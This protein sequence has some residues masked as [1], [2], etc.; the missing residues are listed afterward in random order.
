M[1]IAGQSLEHVRKFKDV[2]VGQRVKARQKT[3]NLEAKEHKCLEEKKKLRSLL[4]DAESALDTSNDLIM[5]LDADFHILKANLA[6]LRFVNKPMHEI[7]G[8]TC[9]KLIHGLETPP[10]E[11]PL[12]TIKKSRKH[13]EVEC[14][15]SAKDMWLKV[16]SDPIFNEKGRMTKIAHIVRDIT[17]FRRTEALLRASESRFRAVFDYASHGIHV[18]DLG[19]RQTLMVN[20]TLSDMLGYSKEEIKQMSVEKLYREKDLPSILDQLRKLSREEIDV[21]RDVA[22]RKKGGGILY[23]HASAAPFILENRTYLMCIYRRKKAGNA[24]TIRGGLHIF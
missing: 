7:I 9:H 21:A 13:E 15:L 20:K 19:K 10:K 3:E 12:N 1:S 6:T 4:R 22:L 18:M 8:K 5:V 23:A 2:F 14:Y 16:T 11:C 24:S 17:E